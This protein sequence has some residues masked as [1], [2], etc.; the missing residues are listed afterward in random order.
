MSQRIAR[1]LQDLIGQ[2]GFIRVRCIGC[3][4]SADFRVSDMLAHRQRLKLST[5]W[6]AVKKSFRCKVCGRVRLK[7]YFVID[8]QIPIQHDK[9]PTHYVPAGVDVRA[10]LAASPAE[11]QRMVKRARG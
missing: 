1:T 2:L 9:P 4:R 6:A 3:N 10:F 8:E 11:R 7:V 5:D